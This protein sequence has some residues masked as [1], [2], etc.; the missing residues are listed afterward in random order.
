ME[1]KE[2]VEY[3]YEMVVNIVAEMVAD[4][5]KANPSELEEQI[6]YD[7]NFE[8]TNVIIRNDHPNEMVA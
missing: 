7:V 8:I 3:Q 1:V 4:Y 5:L 2:S 6:E